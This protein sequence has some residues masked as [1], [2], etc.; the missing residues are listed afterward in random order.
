MLR[1]TQSVGL[2]SG[3]FLP[4]K[5]P[6]AGDFVDMREDSQFS[7]AM[8]LEAVHSWGCTMGLVV[9]LTKTDRQAPSHQPP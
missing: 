5:T 1:L 9:D 8:L 4:F 7:P 6:L 2:M 3:K